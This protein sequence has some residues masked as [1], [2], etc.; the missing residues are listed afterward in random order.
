LYHCYTYPARVNV[1][2]DS[3]LQRQRITYMVSD[4]GL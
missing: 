4:P 2:L 3:P 1:R